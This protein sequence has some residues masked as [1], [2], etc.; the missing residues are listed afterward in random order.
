MSH[1]STIFLAGLGE[2]GRYVLEFLARDEQHFE[3]FVSDLDWERTEKIVNNARIG[4]QHHGKVANIHPVELDLLDV[5][6]TAETLSRIQPDIVVNCSVLQ[7]WHVIRQLPEEQYARLSAAT[8][9]AWLP[10]QLTLAY[11]LGQSIKSAGL[12]GHYVNTSLSCLT[13][14]ALGNVGLA[15]TVGVGNVD[16]IQPAVRLLIATKYNVTIEEVDVQ[17]VAHHVHWVTPREVGYEK[18]APFY[19]QVKVQGND[20][21]DDL[22]DLETVLRDAILLYHPDTTFSA[23][24]A[25]STIKNIKALLSDEETETH[26]PAP[27]GLP[28]GYPLKISSKGVD[29]NIPP[30]LSKQEAINLNYRASQF[31]G[32][33]EFQDDGIVIFTE[34][35]YDIM[36]QMLNFDCKQFHVDE[37]QELAFEQISKY[38]AFKSQFA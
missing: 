30:G 16:L 6:K 3:I 15:P 32:I 18:G 33:Q 11:R 12:T 34:K 35:T 24:S 23:V 29:L 36:K 9:G 19:M 21:T 13:N 2:V 22:G 26:S 10:V 25:S 4:S 28:G 31:D 5:D 14:P 20:I 27:A 17:L 38:Q 37:C 7:T 8:L 1:H